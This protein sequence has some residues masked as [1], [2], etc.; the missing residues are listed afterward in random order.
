MSLSNL[1]GLKKLVQLDLQ[2]DKNEELIINKLLCKLQRELVLQ[3]REFRTIV[4]G[5][6]KIP[7][8]LEKFLWLQKQEVN[9][10]NIEDQ[11]SYDEIIG[12]LIDGEDQLNKITWNFDDII[13][14]LEIFNVCSYIDTDLIHNIR[15]DGYKDVANILRDV[16]LLV[17]K[18]AIHSLILFG[19]NL[20]EMILL[21]QDLEREKRKITVK[22]QKAHQTHIIDQLQLQFQEYK[23]DTI[24]LLKGLLQTEEINYYG[25][26]N[27]LD[28]Q[29]R[30]F[31]KDKIIEVSKLANLQEKTYID[32]EFITKLIQTYSIQNSKLLKKIK[33]NNNL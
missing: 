2:S 20:S 1:L 27:Q 26:K 32:Q 21:K 5:N 17:R 23:K 30:L 24:L 25:I 31:M 10:Q 4:A 6:P 29:Y 8:L 15:K 14:L 19:R 18:S 28:E 13:E 9:L 12:C 3:R 16:K 7:V 33:Y 11:Q 22:I